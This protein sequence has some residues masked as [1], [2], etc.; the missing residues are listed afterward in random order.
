MSF[1]SKA[2]GDA[3]CPDA[4]ICFADNVLSFF[5]LLALAVGRGR[6]DRGQPPKFQPVGE[7][8]A[9]KIGARSP[10]FGETWGQKWNF[11]YLYIL[12]CRTFAAV[13]R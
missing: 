13:C 3:C 12:L 2:T 6:G 10:H 4:V 1:W 9:K 5:Y 7:F 8:S 11:E